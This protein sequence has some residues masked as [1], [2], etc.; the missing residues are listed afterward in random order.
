LLTC[1]GTCWHVP[2][3]WCAVLDSPL[4][5]DCL[6]K[7]DSGNAEDI[8][9]VCTLNILMQLVMLPNIDLYFME[10]ITHNSPGHLR[11]SILPTGENN[12]EDIHYRASWKHLFYWPIKRVLE[13]V[14]TELG[15]KPMARNLTFPDIENV[16]ILSSEI[17]CL[18]SNKWEP[19]TATCRYK[20]EQH[21]HRDHKNPSTVFAWLC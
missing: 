10:N 11:L 4:S 2:W 16:S 14:L 5:V 9:H 17:L 15:I 6:C 12:N 21:S 18:Y 1:V 13:G 19:F 8:G 7:G 3:L 20:G